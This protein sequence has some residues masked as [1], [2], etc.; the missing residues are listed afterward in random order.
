MLS[1]IPTEGQIFFRKSDFVAESI[2][3]SI[4][5]GL[6]QP[7]TKITEQEVQKLLNVSSSPIRE[8]FHQLETEGFLISTPHTGT[9]VPE[10]DLNAVREYYALRIDV[11]EIAI[12]AFTKK[13]TEED[14]NEA[15]RLCNAM[16]KAVDE[17]NNLDSL[18]VLN[19]RFHMIVCGKNIFP[20]FAN[21]VS[22]LWVRLPNKILYDIPEERAVAMDY[23]QKIIGAIRNGDEILAASLMREHLEKAQI[24]MH[25]RYGWDLPEKLKK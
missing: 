11:E 12:R 17:G 5:Q 19:Y 23:H 9:R 1:I 21:L 3:M 8:A 7:G 2:R 6:I 16:I 25:I 20:W 13:L 18:R 10:I 15:Q 4:L 24:A 22:I 14:I